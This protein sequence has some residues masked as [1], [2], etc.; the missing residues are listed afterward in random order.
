M[1]TATD[2][3][4]GEYQAGQQVSVTVTLRR[5][6]SYA[7]EAIGLKLRIRDES[8]GIDEVSQIVVLGGMETRQV[9]LQWTVPVSASS[10]SYDLEVST[11]DLDTGYHTSNLLNNDFNGNEATLEA[12]TMAELEAMSGLS[13]KRD[14]FVPLDNTGWNNSSF[15]IGGGG[16]QPT[17]SSDVNGDNAVNVLDMIMVGQR[18]GQTGPAGWVAE[19]VNEDGAVNVLDTILIG[20]NWTG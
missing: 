20:Q 4:S 2:W 14:P 19:D 11:W 15:T 18:W 8:G 5:G 12:I 6:D 1:I 16:S 9:T 10:G 17:S 13:G 3:P 7:A